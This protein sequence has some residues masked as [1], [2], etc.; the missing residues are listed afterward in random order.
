MVGLEPRL[1]KSKIRQQRLAEN[2]RSQPRLALFFSL[3]AV[4]SF[5]FCFTFPSPHMLSHFAFCFHSHEQ[6]TL[7]SS[8]AVVL[9][10]N[11]KGTRAHQ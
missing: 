6:D 11:T 8:P 7:W 9:D 5:S 2:V 10:P 4:H 1:D 3:L